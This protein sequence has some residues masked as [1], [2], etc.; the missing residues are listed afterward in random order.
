MIQWMLHS[1]W[2]NTAAIAV[3]LLLP[4]VVTVVRAFGS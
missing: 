1:G 2:P 4:L 3:V